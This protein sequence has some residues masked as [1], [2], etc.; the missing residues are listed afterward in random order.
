M[1]RVTAII[2]TACVKE[3][4]D[5]LI[6][7]I[8]SLHAASRDPITILVIIN[9]N[10]F[11]STL[12]AKLRSREDI[13]VDQISE[14]SAPLA[15][16]HGRTL[17]ETDF[18]CFLDDDDEYLA[19]AI[20]RRI[21]ALEQEPTAALIATNGYR[22]INGID[23]IA[24]Q[25]LQTVPDDP[26]FAL[27]RENWLASCGCL[28]RTHEVGIEFFERPHEYLEWT[29][30]AFRIARSGKRIV[31]LDQPGF[32]IFDTPSSVSKTS[33]YL[34][35]H[36][37]LYRRMLQEP[38]PGPVSSEIRKRLAIALNMQ[39]LASLQEES[40]G[41]AWAY[42]LQALSMRGGWRYATQTLRLASA[43]I[44]RIVAVAGFS[45]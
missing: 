45:R 39:S 26:L 23:T 4:A 31:V 42:H 1:P 19:G 11:D 15:Q 12:A 6:R 40:L 43:S 20:D 32:R 9:G 29:W 25:Q 3:R 5:S 22:H 30:L 36:V 37:A 14:G 2:P 34:R 17:V 7:A 21:T 44:K 16:L 41:A 35:S 8:S 38:L 24:F 28:F 13:E 33:A 18:F 27:F 10:R